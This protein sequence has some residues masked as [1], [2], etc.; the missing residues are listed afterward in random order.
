VAAK[1]EVRIEAIDESHIAPY[2]RLSAN[3]FGDDAL[4]AN[5]SHLRW[6]FLDNPAG[7]SAGVH[8]YS[9]G[10]LVG[11]YVL[12]PRLFTSGGNVHR[13]A[14]SV[15]VL[16]D[17]RHRRLDVLMRLLSALKRLSDFDLLLTIT[18]NAAGWQVAKRFAA[19]PE[20]F[21]F[22]VAAAPIGP[23]EILH[24][25]GTLPWRGLARAADWPWRG[26]T[27]AIT[28]FGG[29][30]GRFRVTEQWPTRPA[31]DALLAAAASDRLL[32][33]D[34]SYDFLD[35]RFRRAPSFKYDVQF[36]YRG[37]DLVGYLASRRTRYEAYDCRFLVDA[38]GLPD[39]TRRDWAGALGPLLSREARSGAAMAMMFT[40]PDCGSMSALMMPPFL[41]VPSRFLPRRMTVFGRWLQ[42]P[43][44][45]LDQQS[46]YLTLADYDVA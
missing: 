7:P 42:S 30:F 45:A 34:R 9:E 12:L 3:E 8:L 19:L 17:S 10:E 14:I 43:G 5:P 32:V 24:A 4:V 46:L 37:N 25:R 26:I 2:A 28:A 39:L 29:L 27:A 40:S 22:D 20:C 36:L 18:P 35:W 13:A 15:D 38:F 31:L 23:A 6:K 44:P 1:Y 11:R 21:D 41:R 33:G 16:I